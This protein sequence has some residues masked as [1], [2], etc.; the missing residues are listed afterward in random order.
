MNFEIKKNLM[1]LE[2][3]DLA[4]L[5][6]QQEAD[7]LQVDLSY[8]ERLEILLQSLI[9]ERK[10]RL[11]S[12]LIHNAYFKYPNASIESL[13][14][15]LRQINK[16]T[17]VN[18]SS[19]GFVN[20]ATNL[21]ISGP[22]GSGK[23]YLACTLGIEACKQTYRVYYIK[24]HDLLRILDQLRD[25]LKE[26]AKFKRRLAN[27]N[28]LIL[29]EWL[30]YAVSERESKHLYELFEMRCGIKPTIFVGQYSQND[31]HHRLGGGAL[32]D[33][34]MDRIVHNSYEIP[35]TE[36]NLRKKYDSEIAAKLL[37]SLES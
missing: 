8:S 10:N 4:K 21:I 22:T 7:L 16:S 24:M 28:I 37:K 27:Y 29:D 11:I 26:Q 35:S 32:A 36:N 25:N 34:I 20:S 33:S 2:L 1:K 3:S 30:N 31:W 5:V 17:I 18:L 23:T 14:C 15:T 9:E 13:D 6:E 12:R 19:M